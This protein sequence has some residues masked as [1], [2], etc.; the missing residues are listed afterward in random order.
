MKKTITAVLLLGASLFS[1]NAVATPEAFIAGVHYKSTASLLATSS[2]DKVE[3]I[4]MFSYSCPHCYDL[5]PLIDEWK[6]TLSENV[7]FVVVPAIFR[8]SWLE[9]AK[10]FYTAEATGDFEKLHPLI[11]EA[12]HVEK[13]RMVTEDD[14]LDFVADQGIDRDNFEKMMNSFAVKGKVKKALIMSQV[15]GIT[16]VPAMIVN[17]KYISTGPMA[18]GHPQLL[19][20]VDFLIQKESE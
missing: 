15:S 6:Q 4:E 12:I 7:V 20:A 11:F 13:R 5:D 19:K 2:E 17:G 16:G 8:D 10:L 14:M 9:L 3:V 18:G 1:L